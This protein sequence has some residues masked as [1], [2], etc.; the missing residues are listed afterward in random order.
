MFHRGHLS[1]YYLTNSIY[2]HLFQMSF[3]GS[4]GFHT[5]SKKSLVFLLKFLSDLVP[6]EP[7]QYLKVT[8]CIC[9]WTKI[10]LT[11]TEKSF[12]GWNVK[13]LQENINPTRKTITIKLLLMHNFKQHITTFGFF[14]ATAKNMNLQ[15]QYLAEDNQGRTSHILRWNICK[16]FC[17]V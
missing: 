2:F 14:F 5:N 3:S 11:L 12:F 7:P 8:I 6:F 17:Q 9:I 1:S 13:H 4:S 15:Q 10:L 16:L